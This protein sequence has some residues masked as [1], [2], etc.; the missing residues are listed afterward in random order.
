MSNLS[1]KLLILLALG[2]GVAMAGCDGDPASPAEETVTLPVVGE[3]AH[4]VIADAD[5]GGRPFTRAM[6]QEV[7]HTPPWEGDPDGSGVA[8]L[9]LNRGQGQVCWET[10][11]SDLTLPATASHIHQQV[12]GVRGPI[13]IFLSPPD[14]TGRATGCRSDVDPELIGEILRNPTGFYV[15]V[16]TSDFPAGAIRAQLVD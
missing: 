16:H 4:A 6:T 11:T 14:A 9:T 10:T 7:T 2:A 12:A 8:V 3:V 5:H 1:T 15:N 13:V